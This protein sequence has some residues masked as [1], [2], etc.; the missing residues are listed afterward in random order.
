MPTRVVLLRHGQSTWNRK[1]RMQ[2]WAETPLTEKGREQARCV[3]AHL[4]D[5]YDPDRIVASDLRRTIETAEIIRNEAFPELEVRE[6]EDWREQDFG[7]YQ[8][9]HVTNF[10][11]QV[12]HPDEA[13]PTEPLENGEAITDVRERA[14]QGLKQL[15]TDDTG[16]VI[17]VS[18][19]GTIVQLLAHLRDIPPFEANK[20]INVA[21]CSIT[22][23][24]LEENATEILRVN[25]RPFNCD[26]DIAPEN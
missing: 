24:H 3:A 12:D 17:V 19:A 16:T 4:A 1:D 18:H 5:A 21:N 14:V 8:G 7:V 26:E 9:L 10:Q 2:G 25:D 15:R 22:E 6:D 23:I 13:D 11:R 20:R